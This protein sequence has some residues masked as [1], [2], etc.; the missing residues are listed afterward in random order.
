MISKP[1]LSVL[2]LYQIKDITEQHN[3]KEAQYIR[4]N[5]Q[6]VSPNVFYMKQYV[7]N[8]CGTIGLLH[9]L[10]NSKHHYE[11]A[12]DPNCYLA[13]L[14]KDTSSMS[15]EERG[16]YIEEDTVIEDMHVESA[17]DGE[18]NASMDTNGHFIAFSVVDGYLYELDG[19]KGSVINHGEC[20]DILQGAARVIGDFMKRDPEEVNFTIVALAANTD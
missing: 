11:S 2:L 10:G 4:D 18:T 7:G 14:F 17:R 20:D 19:R 3:E 5:G 15:P 9:A 12:L 1:V 8:A 13:R 16:K 6:I